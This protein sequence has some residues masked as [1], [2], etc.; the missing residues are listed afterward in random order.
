MRGPAAGG[1]AV[2][3]DFWAKIGSPK[4]VAAPMVD[5]S[6]LPFRLLCRQLGTQLTYTPMLHARL[7]LEYDSYR[8]NHF[9]A[10]ADIDEG[11]VF[12]QLAGH[13]PTTVLAAARHVE[14]H[15]DAVDLNFGCPQGIARK[16]RY[17]AFLLDE[18]D[19]MVAV[20][21]EL[22]RQ[23]SVPVTAKTRMLPNLEETI[24]ICKRLEDAGASVLCLHGRTRQQNKQLCGAAN[25]D[26]IGEVVRQVG[27]PVI[28]NGGISS[29]DDVDRCLEHT[30]AAAVMSSEALLENPALFCRNVDPETGEYIDQTELALRYLRLCENHA[31]TKGAGMLRPHLFKFLHHG[32]KTHT[33]LR[34]ELLV[35]NGVDELR[36]VVHQLAACEWQQPAFHTPHYRAECA[37]YNRYR[38]ELLAAAEEGAAL[39]GAANLGRS[40]RLDS[41]GTVAGAR[42]LGRSDFEA[43]TIS[44]D[45]LER[46]ALEKRARKAA[47]RKAKHSN[48]NRARSER[49]K[50]NGGGG[51]GSNRG[52]SGGGGGGGGGQPGGSRIN[53]VATKQG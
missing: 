5:Q 26:A 39:P 28:A 48:R 21:A 22:G 31:P 40:G 18:P 49:R 20:V 11:P 10:R 45:E 34:D 3:W 23:L 43:E 2:G 8:A 42:F 41:S 29:A 12:A 24:Q 17:G 37:W 52:V 13:D 32:L 6:E 51:P 1:H 53:A 47:L 30:G 4:Y 27:I 36:E 46:R 35:S 25:W 38:P 14:A 19:T 15:V 50:A 44:K 33:H 9:D 7:M 16:G